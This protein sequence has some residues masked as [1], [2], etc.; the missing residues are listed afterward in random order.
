VARMKQGNDILRRLPLISLVAANLIPVFGVVF[1]GWDAFNIV[2]LYWAENIAVGFYNILKM[3]FVSVKN[4]KEHLGKLFMIPFFTL[5]FG[6]FTG[7]HGVF[8]LTMFRK[9]GGEF[10]NRVSWPCFLAFVQIL[11]N[12]MREAY[13]V[14]SP[15]MR[16]AVLALFASHGV[17]FVYNYLI[18]GEYARTNLGKLM[19]APYA[20][21]VVMHVAIIAGGFPLMVFG[22]PA[23]L[24]F[25]LVVLKTIIDIKLHLWEHKEK[26]A[27]GGVFRAMMNK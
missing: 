11:L 17:S 8:V 15:N 22:S 5:H 12:M 13:S 18:K 16:L 3:A 20:R 23:G 25:V 9:S 6:G 21:V 27:H 4:H 7:I 10:M 19:G 2:L 24:L 14:M 1:A 26:S